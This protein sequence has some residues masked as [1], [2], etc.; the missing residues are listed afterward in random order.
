MLLP[1]QPQ[2]PGL[3]VQRVPPAGRAGLWSTPRR[4]HA[5]SRPLRGRVS[6][7][8]GLREATIAGGRQPGGCL[9]EGV[10]CW[11]VSRGLRPRKEYMYPI[12][13]AARRRR[14]G[15]RT[16]PP[17]GTRPGPTGSTGSGS[18]RAWAWQARKLPAASTSPSAWACQSRARRE[19]GTRP[20]RPH[21]TAR[22]GRKR[23]S[24]DAGPVGPSPPSRRTANRR[25][26]RTA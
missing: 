10:G 7:R 26:L 15:W 16:A 21:G 20:R 23:V 22:R 2:P 1:P 4:T 8:R 25:L 18:W 5:P 19:P 9:G 24:G 12:E 17:T 11:V 3:P 6:A 14:R 13:T